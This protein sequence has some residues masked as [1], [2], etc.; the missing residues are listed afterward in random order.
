MR[1]KTC[2]T[3]CDYVVGFEKLL[4]RIRMVKDGYTY[5]GNDPITWNLLVFSGDYC[6]EIRR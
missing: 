4:I 1:D 5:F 2:L 6:R 3:S